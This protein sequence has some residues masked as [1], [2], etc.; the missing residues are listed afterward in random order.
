MAG[1]LHGVKVL[2][3][4]RVLAGPWSSQI[5]ADLG[6]DVI[7]IERPGSGDDTRSWGPPYA[8]DTSGAPTPESAYFL[9]T[10]RGKKSVTIDIATTEGQALVSGLAEQSDI[11]IE[12]FKA[13]G[14]ANYSLDYN[15]L[16]QLN[17]GLIYCSITGFGQTGPYSHLPGYDFL[18]QGMGG[19]MSITGDADN[20]SGGGPIKTGVAVAD[21]F[22]GLYATVAILAALNRRHATGRGDQID[23]AL[24]DVQ[25]AMLANQAMNFLTTGN[26]PQRLGNAHPNIVPY[27]SF[28]T[29]DGYVVLAV[30]NDDQFRAFCDGAGRTEL[31][32]DA[33]FMTNPARVANRDALIPIIANVLKSQ[34]TRHWLNTFSAARVPAGPINTIADVF[35][36]P[37]VQARGLLLDLPHATAGRVPSVANP[38]R[39]G[40][41]ALDAAAGPPTLGQHTTDVLSQRL[42][43]SRSEIDAL[44]AAGAI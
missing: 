10:N 37:H 19:L 20:A 22:S 4:S 12:N 39:F 16:A 36:D 2:D 38:I 8:K 26:A 3:L 5:L 13:G 43:L 17:P 44:K 27:Q 24:L 11:L 9:S 41:S 28:A 42:G 23:I 32:A 15:T 34:T 30:G 1:P 6:A 14:L 35:A 29:Q 33:R 21:L 25:V 40:G 7:K 31:A 18:I